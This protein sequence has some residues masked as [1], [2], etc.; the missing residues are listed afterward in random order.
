[1][2]TPVSDLPV[3]LACC[4]TCPFKLDKNGRNEM[5]NWLQK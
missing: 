5:L 2:K 3:M 4:K 1:M